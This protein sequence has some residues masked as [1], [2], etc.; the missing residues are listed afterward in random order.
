MIYFIWCSLVYI[1]KDMSSA[2]YFLFILFTFSRQNVANLY[3]LVYISVAA[4][5]TVYRLWTITQW[6][7]PYV[8][9]LT[10]N[11]LEPQNISAAI[12]KIF[13]IIAN[14]CCIVD[15]HCNGWH[16]ERILRGICQA[17]MKCSLR[18]TTPLAFH[19]SLIRAVKC[20]HHHY[21]KSSRMVPIWH[22][23]LTMHGSLTHCN[24]L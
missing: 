6:P 16:E 15:H 17:V 23:I 21:I 20:C 19:V 18:I 1:I 7:C 9:L 5:M 4:D 14:G 11:I 12:N 13:L 2:N 22:I 8:Y 10:L 3:L 24:N